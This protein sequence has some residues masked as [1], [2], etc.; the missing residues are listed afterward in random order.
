MYKRQAVNLAKEIDADLVMA[1]DPDAD[2][3]GSACKDDKGEW[4]LINGNQTCMTVSYTHLDVYKRQ[5]LLFSSFSSGCFCFFLNQLRFSV[6]GV[7]AKAESASPLSNIHA[8]TAAITFTYILI[9]FLT[10]NS[11][12]YTHLDVYKRQIQG[13]GKP[14]SE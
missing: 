9:E 4:V 14:N 12:S 13:S 3:V 10:F 1:S 11:V 7:V 6:A 8:M 2:R 5:L